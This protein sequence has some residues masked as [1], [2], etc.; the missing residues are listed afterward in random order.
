ML[1]IRIEKVG[2]WYI[3]YSLKDDEE[4]CRSKK[5]KGLVAVSVGAVAASAVIPDNLV[6]TLGTKFLTVPSFILN[7][8]ME[9][10]LEKTLSNKKLKE[11]ESSNLHS[12][13]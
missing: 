4:L 10:V 6:A 13:K 12:I 8:G 11:T 9:E 2:D 7:E 1:R 5:V 3:A